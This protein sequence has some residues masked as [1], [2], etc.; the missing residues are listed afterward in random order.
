MTAL[1]GE[2]M[3]RYGKKLPRKNN[4]SITAE[5]NGN[6]EWK[7][8]FEK[9]EII[10]TKPSSN[11]DTEQKCV[12]YIAKSEQGPFCLW[13]KL[14]QDNSLSFD[15]NLFTHMRINDNAL[16]KAFISINTKVQQLALRP[17]FNKLKHKKYNKSTT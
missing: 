2:H 17:G 16:Q 3:W 5:N 12:F 13:Y 4:I 9:K 11:T 1:L 8:Q 10:L 15:S 14:D 7:L 6:T